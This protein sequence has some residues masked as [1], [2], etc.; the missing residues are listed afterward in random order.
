MVAGQVITG[1]MLSVTVTIWAQV[2]VFPLASVA[3]QVTVVVPFGK[4]AGALLLTVVPVQLSLIAGVP[5]FTP[6]ALQSEL[7]LT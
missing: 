6:V 3:V 1:G 7:V 2:A 4:T 5:R